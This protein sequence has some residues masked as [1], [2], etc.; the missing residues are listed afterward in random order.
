[1]SSYQ[2]AYTGQEIDVAIGSMQPSLGYFTHL[3]PRIQ[4]NVDSLVF[5]FSGALSDGVFGANLSKSA[6]WANPGFVSTVDPS[7]GVTDSVIRLPNLAFDYAGGESVA[8]CWKGQV[9]PEVSDT[10][11]LGDSHLNSVNNGVGLRVRST[12]KFDLVLY[13]LANGNG[14]SG[15]TTGIPFVTGETHSVCVFINGVSRAYAVYVDGVVDIALQTLA[16]GAAKNTLNS[17]TFNI[18]TGA[19]AAAASTTGIATKTLALAI[20]KRAAG[21]GLPANLAGIAKSFHRNPQALITRN[22]W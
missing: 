21:Q 6:A 9:T 18:G 12:G 1:M 13:D 5:D 4:E 16:S 3:Y 2:S 22:A 20:L 15:I 8:I 10:V 14:F 11:F 19:R 7:A 17:E